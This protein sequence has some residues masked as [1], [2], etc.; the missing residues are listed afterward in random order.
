[1]ENIRLS[2]YAYL[3]DVIITSKQIQELDLQITKKNNKSS[4]HSFK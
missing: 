1:M 4:D 3:Y 2:V